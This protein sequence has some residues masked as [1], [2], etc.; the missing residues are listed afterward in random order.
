MEEEEIGRLQAENAGYTKY[1][2]EKTNQL[3]QVMGTEALRPEEFDDRELLNLDPIGIIAGAFEQVIDNLNTTITDLSEARDELQ[4][5]FDA[6]GVGISIIDE[7]FSILKCNEKQ[8]ELL[9]D[10]KL[11]NACG[12]YCYEIYCRKD[13]PGLDCPAVDTFATGRPVVVNEVHKKDKY[14]QLITTPFAKDDQGRVTRVIEVAL[15]ITARKKAEE[16]EKRQR[17]YYLAEKSKLFS[18]LQSLSEGLLVTDS[19]NRIIS[20]NGAALQILDLS[21]KQIYTQTIQE[22]FADYPSDAGN[23]FGISSPSTYQNI[24]V[25]FH[26]ENKELLLS[27]N[28]VPLCDTDGN[29][30]GRVF[31][32]YNI[33]E[34]KHRQEVYHRTEKLAAIGQLSAGLAH[35]LNTPLGSILGYARLLLKGDNFSDAQRERLIIIAEQAKKSSTIIRGLLNFSRLSAKPKKRPMDCDLNQ[36]ISEAVKIIRTELDKRDISIEL[37][38]SPLPA[39]RADSKRLEQVIVNM[40]L[41]SA[42]AID[43][44]GVISIQSSH[45]PDE[46]QIKITD[47][48]AGI[49]T[50][51]LSRIFDP[52][53]TTKPVGQGTGLGLSTC[54]GII[55]DYGGAIDVRNSTENG[56]V[57]IITLPVQEKNDA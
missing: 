43:K 27:I 17:G 41:N 45:L 8:R 28:S 4:A 33:S 23:I 52:F 24:E 14:F 26:G 12:Q 13:G 20:A 10:E 38:L 21:Q 37:S 44:N 55:N 30:R 49:P 39:V 11:V 31:T 29:S 48:G 25:N 46:V 6:T 54:S 22:I 53:F 51:N 32:F 16:E 47:T 3:L 35:E 50:E 34:E 56:A 19:R 42:Q 40:L 7:D 18:I 2:R 36:V 15:D 5:I 9:V 1:I 57:F